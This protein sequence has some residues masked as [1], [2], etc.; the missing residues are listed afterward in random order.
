MNSDSRRHP[1]ATQAYADTLRHVGRPFDV[2]E[3]ETNVIV[4][5]FGEGWSDAMGTYPLC[6]PGRTA[7]IQGG[8]RRLEEQG[9]LSA[10]L[11]VDGLTGPALPEMTKHFRLHRPYKTHYLVDP[12]VGGYQP[13][14]HHAQEI[15]R[16]ARHDLELRSVP[17]ADILSDWTVLYEH[18]GDRHAV[19]EV[20]RFSSNSFEALGR[21]GGV[22]AVAAF[23]DRR[24]LCC[25]LWIEHEDIVWSHLAASS[26][27]GYE[28]G[29]AYLVY[30]TSLRHFAG[31]LVN[32]GGPAGRVD[33]P[34][35]GLARFKSGF[36]NRTTASYLL[37]A[38]LDDAAYGE[39]C[40]DKAEASDYFPAYRRGPPPET[41]RDHLR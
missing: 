11:V 14:R 21:C 2:P 9:L 41:R 39:L 29:A 22:H 30:D 36:S 38:V 5:P 20:Q 15:R 31:R 35:D 19:G 28:T 17:F 26:P 16:A 25:H 12:A 34:A 18:L 3:W 10:T 32:L 13:S 27:E 33:D 6:C 8:L 7:D 40:A 1:Y 4:R 23:R 24:L 37:G